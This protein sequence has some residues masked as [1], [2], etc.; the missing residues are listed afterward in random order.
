MQARREVTF[1]ANKT[2]EVKGP[3][4]GESARFQSVD[5]AELANVNVYFILICLHICKLGH[6]FNWYSAL[7]ATEAGR[8]PRELTFHS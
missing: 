2:T 7:S 3:E 1:Q 5:R 4:N 6:Q 8:K